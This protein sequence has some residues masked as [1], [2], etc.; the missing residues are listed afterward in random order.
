MIT[1]S[2]FLL[3]PELLISG[4][5]EPDDPARA[6]IITIGVGL[7]GAAALFQLVDGA[8]V[9][10]LGLL[11]GMQDTER[12]MVIAALSY[13]VVGIPSSYI[14]GFPL[15]LGGIGVWLGLVLGLACAGI[16]LMVRFWRTGL[17]GLSTAQSQT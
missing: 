5:L 3:I 10:A 13:W 8:Q 12:P 2:M 16:L 11:R 15:G 6:Q 9:I 7:L 1:I 17:N 14:L 4:F